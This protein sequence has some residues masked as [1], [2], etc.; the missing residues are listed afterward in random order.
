MQLNQQEIEQSKENVTCQTHHSKDTD[1]A[2]TNECA[3]VP[4]PGMASTRRVR[5]CRPSAVLEAQLWEQGDQEDQGPTTQSAGQATSQATCVGGGSSTQ[6]AVGT[7]T[8]KED[9]SV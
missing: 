8:P 7:S 3:T 9:R 6:W 5:L 1:L 4:F 2:L